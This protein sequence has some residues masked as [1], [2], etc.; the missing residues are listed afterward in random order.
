M[1]PIENLL[2]DELKRVADTVQPGQLRPLRIPAPGR[3]W[4]HRLLPVAAA[5][6]VIAVAVAAVL[7]ARPK[8]APPS[9]SDTA[10]D[11]LRKRMWCSIFGAAPTRS[12]WPPSSDPKRLARYR[13]RTRPCSASKNCN[14]S[15]D[16]AVAS[17]AFS[18]RPRRIKSNA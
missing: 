10:A 2:R 14:G 8:P 5:A 12:R 11:R 18:F 6:A 3:R 13:R 9:A 15:R 7:V 16:W 17:H 4:H 1:P